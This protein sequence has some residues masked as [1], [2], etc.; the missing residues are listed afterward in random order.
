MYACR[1]VQDLV[2][3]GSSVLQ[4]HSDL[5]NSC[6]ELVAWLQVRWAARPQPFRPRA[7]LQ[8]VADLRLRA[9]LL[10]LYLVGLLWAL[11]RLSLCLVLG[12]LLGEPFL[13]FVVLMP[14]Y[15]RQV[16]SCA[17]DEIVGFG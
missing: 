13:P 9:H 1:V 17:C 10:R 12:E 11:Q 4:T 2:L 8:L 16:C 15:T 5:R 7:I 3:L 6:F 14:I